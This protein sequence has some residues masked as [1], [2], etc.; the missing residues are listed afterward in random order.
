[1]KLKATIVVFV[2][3]FLGL[4]LLLYVNGRFSNDPACSEFVSLNNDAE[5]VK[6]LSDD[7]GNDDL[8]FDIVEDTAV[9][10]SIFEICKPAPLDG[11]SEQIVR[12]KAYIVSYNKDTKIPNWVAWHLTSEHTDGPIGRTNAFYE[13][14]AVPAPRATIED[15]K[16]S[17]WSRGHM[18]PAGDNKWDAEAMIQSFS[19]INVC[20]Q[21]ASLN[22]GLWNS[23][24]I[25]CRNWAK[26]FGDIFIICGPVFF[27]GKHE[28]IGSND[29]YVPEAF[30]KVV[31]CLNGTPKGMGIVVKNNSNTKK[32]D[33]YFNSIDQVERITGMDFFPMLPDEIENEVESNIDLDLWK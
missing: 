22:S 31:L 32:R 28:T 17:G 20:P 2:V 9:V 25:D 12:K 19:L 16:G 26:R 3:A 5:E 30:F 1:M 24:E 11:V 13:D 15:Y 21:D 10:D 27:R 6:E 18:C 33:L 14:D 29:V 4:I 8:D 23:F 7:S